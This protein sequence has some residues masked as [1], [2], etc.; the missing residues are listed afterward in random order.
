MTSPRPPEPDGAAP[1]TTRRDGN[2][3]SD[4]RRARGHAEDDMLRRLY[5]H[6]AAPGA[7]LRLHLR[8]W[9]KRFLWRTVVAASHALKRILDILGAAAGL[10]LLSPFFA[11]TALLIVLEDGSPALFRQIRVGRHGA[12]FRM[13]KFRSMYKDAE[14]RLRDLQ[15]A[16]ESSDGVTFKM[17]RDPR[18]TRVGKYIRKASIDELPQ[19]WNVLRGEMSLV[20]PRPAIPAEVAQYTLEDRR[21]LAVKPGV[22]CFWQVSG[23]SS[24][25]FKDQ[26]R[27]DVA[28]I[29]SQSLRLD[30][31]LLLKTIPA[32]LS[33]RGAY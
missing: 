31:L 5:Q 11:L 14:T 3:A 9:R 1:P 16:N 17:R 18:I 27:L 25:P 24:I 22:T 28:Y 8:L 13:Y 19:L 10:A 21:R 32:V 15:S 4:L 20:G 23:R 33:G 12:P 26:V 30:V 6:Y 29:E 2:A 7:G